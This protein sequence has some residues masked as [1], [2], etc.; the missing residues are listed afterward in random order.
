M[1]RM[2][3]GIVCY[4]HF[5]Y[6]LRAKCI[7]QTSKFQ[8]IWINSVSGFLF[9]SIESVSQL[10]ELFT[11][12]F[13]TGNVKH[14]P[15]AC[16]IFLHVIRSPSSEIWFIQMHCWPLLHIRPSF[17]R[18]HSARNAYINCMS[19]HDEK[20]KHRM[21]SFRV[22][23]SMNRAIKYSPITIWIA[24]HR[25]CIIVSCF[26]DSLCPF[27]SCIFFYIYVFPNSLQRMNAI[28]FVL[29]HGRIYESVFVQNH[30]SKRKLIAFLKHQCV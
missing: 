8:S 15:E 18:T 10:L 16:S 23:S 13:C 12:C 26:L 29:L 22:M 17:W 4:F 1:G 21:H 19:L 7:E 3:N 27:F 28:S 20:K 9:G 24:L 2:K 25:N 11:H 30:W 14:L 5:Q 6:F